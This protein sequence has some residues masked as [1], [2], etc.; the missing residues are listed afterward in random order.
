MGWEQRGNHSYYYRK[1]RKGSRVKS[2]YV[3]RG[4]IANM[5]S[6]LQ[7]TSQVFEKAMGMAYPSKL[8]KLKEQDANIE[9]RCRLVNAITQASLLASGFHT[10]KRQWRKRRK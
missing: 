7:T 9:Q 10:H 3:G 2:V 6:N 1:E 5:I 8:D 4:E